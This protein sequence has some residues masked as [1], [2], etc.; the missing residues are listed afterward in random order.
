MIYGTFRHENFGG[1][2]W[3]MGLLGVKILGGK[4]MWP[5]NKK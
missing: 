4:K 2:E 3:F 5:R 1:K